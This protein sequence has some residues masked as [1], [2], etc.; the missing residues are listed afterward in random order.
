MAAWQHLGRGH[1]RRAGIGITGP[2]VQRSGLLCCVPAL[3]AALACAGAGGEAD[4]SP[5][6]AAGTSSAPT[7]TATGGGGAG[8]V[9]AQGGSAGRP[10]EDDLADRSGGL[11]ED[12]PE[13]EPEPEP[14]S[15]FPESPSCEGSR[16]D[17]CQEESC[18]KREGVNTAELMTVAPNVTVSLSPYALDKFE[19]SVSRFRS[20]V[21]VFDDWRDAGKPGATAGAHPYTPGSGWVS[22][23]AW[24]VALPGSA[25]VLRVG[26]NCNATQQTWTDEPGF[27]E[28]KP[29]NCVS[30]YEAFAFCVWDEGRLPTEA[31]WQ[32][33][34]VGGAQARMFAWGNTPIGDSFTSFNC[35]VA[36]TGGRCTV[37]DIPDVGSRPDGDG[38]FGQ[39]DLVGSLYEW[40]LDWFAPYPE[41]MRDDYA[42]TD[43]GTQRVLRGGAWNSSTTQAMV[44]TDRSLRLAPTSRSPATGIRC[45]R[46]VEESI[47]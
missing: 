32:Y 5:F 15:D 14:V 13:P 42:K 46:E 24:E 8:P 29:I 19:V 3:A 2:R 40:T 31:E 37:D 27:N 12:E 41:L 6:A 43:V 45:A 23:P 33:A 18:C 7:A 16:P 17:A 38:R 4:P 9:L 20:F 11:I 1:S 39:S 10:S 30:W 35:L 47:R 26:L 21:E 44:S 28:N 25:A 22:D 36:G 34:A